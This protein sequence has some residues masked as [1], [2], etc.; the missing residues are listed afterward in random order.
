MCVCLYAEGR[1]EG[2]GEGEGI[3]PPVNARVVPDQPRETQHKLEVSQLEHLKGES[4]SVV[5]MYA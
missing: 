5:A 4:L 3:L 1:T 2:R